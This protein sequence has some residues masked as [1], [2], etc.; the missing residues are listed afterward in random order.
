[1]KRV[2]VLTLLFFVTL[3]CSSNAYAQ[4][5][6]QIMMNL[7]SNDNGKQEVSTLNLFATADRIMLKGEDNYNFM[8]QVSTDGLLIRNDI[9]DFIIMTGNDQAL[10]VTKKEIEGLVEMFSS[11]GGS[12]S[13]S[14]TN[15]T[16]DNRYRF[17]DETREIL[18]HQAAE[19]II[20][21]DE[22]PNKYLSV[23]LTPEIDINWGMLAE[24]W[25]N[26]PADIDK[27]LNG[28]SQEIIFKRKNFP[29][30]IEAVD[31][32]KRV[33]IMETQN[34]NRSNVAKAMVEIPSGVTLMS[35][36]DYVFKMMM[37]Q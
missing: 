24:K 14:G 11:W 13:S 28:M 4:F 8:D 12:S 25:N 10:Q 15:G 29:L 17:S 6:G 35:F 9:K 21:N 3:F 20:E 36:K 18:G 27:E 19:M 30:L 1:M 16:P 7:Y 34:V 31:G 26:M 32:N 37:E 22:D 5:E 23:W 2:S 33:K